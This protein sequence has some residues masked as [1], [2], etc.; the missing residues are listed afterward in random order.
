M[1]EL[2]ETGKKARKRRLNALEVVRL[3]A[4]CRDRL[5]SELYRERAYPGMP[6]PGVKTLSE[7]YAIPLS[8]VRSTLNALRAEGVLESVPR[9]GMK[10]VSLPSR[11]KSLKGIRIA[12][13]AEL[14]ESN[15]DYVYNRSA[16]IATGM[17]RILNEQ[18]GHMDFF[19]LWQ[20][21]DPDSFF[22][23][24]S[25]SGYD[26]LI[27]AIS[28]YQTTDFLREY[29]FLTIPC[30]SIDCNVEGID[31]VDFDDEQIGHRIARHA[32]ELGHRRTL[33]YHYSYHSWSEMRLKGIRKEFAAWGVPPPDVV[34]YPFVREDHEDFV[35]RNFDRIA[36]GNYTFVMAANDRLAKSIL[37]AAR[38]R[39]QKVK[40]GWAEGAVISPGGMPGLQGHVLSCYLG[41]PQAVILE[42]SLFGLPLGTL[43]FLK[44]PP[45]GA[46][47]VASGLICGALGLAWK[48]KRSLLSQKFAL[49]RGI[50]REPASRRTGAQS[51]S[52]MKI[53]RMGCQ[54]A[55]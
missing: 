22:H 35:S 15:P 49:R 38:R 25:H 7:Q 34:D 46:G 19:N 21:T 44:Q 42:V 31:C 1:P 53:R 28:R 8:V 27:V 45:L 14:E 5:V 6:I 18:G 51:R 33:Y 2:Q 41:A 23:Q 9:E 26:A 50:K 43:L 39:K 32:L 3:Q 30:I 29:P 54:T 11:P 36:K 40:S 37:L 55:V 52:S 12:M 24:L 13:I 4:L 17:D 16:E 20:K 47:F 48:H 10:V